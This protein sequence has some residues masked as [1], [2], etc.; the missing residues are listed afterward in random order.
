MIFMFYQN[1]KLH[2]AFRLISDFL[3]PALLYRAATEA[4][5]SAS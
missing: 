1:L 4:R 3:L 5:I 2:V